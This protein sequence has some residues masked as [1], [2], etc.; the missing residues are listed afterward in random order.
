MSK[1]YKEMVL[2]V[3]PKEIVPVLN[4][5]TKRLND[6]KSGRVETELNEKIWVQFEKCRKLQALRE[7][8]TIQ[9]SEQKVLDRLYNERGTWLKKKH[10]LENQTMI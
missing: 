3:I 1:N 6:L 4:S 8:P 7:K 10:D 5:L 2:S 9:M